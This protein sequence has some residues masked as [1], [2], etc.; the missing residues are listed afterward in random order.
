MLLRGGRPLASFGVMGG[1]MQAQGHVQLV[2]RLIDE[3][4]NVQE[5][6]E[7]PRF[8][9]LGG[10]RVALEADLAAAVG[11]ALARRGHVVEDES[12]A[13]LAGGFGGGQAIAV[14][15]TTAVYWGGSDPRKDGSAIGW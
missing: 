11:A 7:G 1:D 2:S 10:D 9:F 6:I 13:L 5:A 3:G 15:P 14:D 8:N 12:A 4:W